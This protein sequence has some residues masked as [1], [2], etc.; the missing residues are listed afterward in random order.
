MMVFVM[1]VDYGADDADD[2]R[3]DINGVGGDCGE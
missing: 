1:S 3:D 2:V